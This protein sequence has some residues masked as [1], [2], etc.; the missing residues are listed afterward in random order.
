MELKGVLCEGCF[1]EQSL[2]CSREAAVVPK[3]RDGS[4]SKSRTWQMGLLRSQEIGEQNLVT[5]N[6]TPEPACHGRAG[7]TAHFE[8]IW[9][10]PSRHTV[11]TEHHQVPIQG[12]ELWPRAAL[13]F[14]GPLVVSQNPPTLESASLCHLHL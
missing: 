3:N 8:S 1:V 14:L 9:F 4:V 5:Y 13:G 10:Q 7:G 2:G 12:L 6:M 11:S